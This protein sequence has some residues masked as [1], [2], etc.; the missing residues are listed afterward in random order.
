MALTN[1]LPLLSYVATQAVLA[2]LTSVLA[3]ATS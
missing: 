1:Q 2:A 3:M